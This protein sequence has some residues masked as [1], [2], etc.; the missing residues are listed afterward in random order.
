MCL[1]VYVYVCVQCVC[2]CVCVKSNFSILRALYHKLQSVCVCVS[3]C[4]CL[5]ACVCVC[6]VKLAGIYNKLKC[7]CLCVCACVRACVRACARACVHCTEPRTVS[8]LLV[9]VLQ[10]GGTVAVCVRDN[11]QQ[12]V[13]STRPLISLY[14]ALSYFC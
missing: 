9:V 1:C 6:Q 8:D 4:V 7:V 3:V 5:S 2:V 13:F 12:R 14:S 10:R 11:L